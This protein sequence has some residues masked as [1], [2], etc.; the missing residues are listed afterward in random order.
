MIGVRG[1]YSF[2]AK[3]EEL[4][5]YPDTYTL[6]YFLRY[7][8]KRYSGKKG[9]EINT[10]KKCATVKTMPHVQI[11]HHLS[12]NQIQD[13]K[14]IALDH[15]GVHR[16]RA[17]GGIC[18]RLKNNLFLTY[19]LGLQ[20]STNTDLQW[21]RFSS[22]D[23]NYYPGYKKRPENQNRPDCNSTMLGGILSCIDAKK[24]EFNS[25]DLILG[26]SLTYIWD[27]SRKAGETGKFEEYSWNINATKM[28]ARRFRAGISGIYISTK[29]QSEKNDYFLVGGIA[30]YEPFLF[31]KHH[32]LFETG[33]MTG[34]YCPCEPENPYRENGIFYFNGGMSYELKIYKELFLDLGFNFYQPINDIK[35]K[36]SYTQYIVGLN[37]HIKK[38]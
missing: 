7:S 34:N 35:G 28:L 31:E 13:G 6:G 11:G 24:K 8:P 38:R 1:G 15:L 30:Q 37:Y 21:K 22:I 36:Y 18:I 33:L 25:K 23:L 10:C 16:I 4:A 26:T 2:Q 29:S 14:N 3:G 19:A 27:D 20:F 32:L 12:N 5:Q 17:E 9:K